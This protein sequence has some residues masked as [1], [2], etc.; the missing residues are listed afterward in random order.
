MAKDIGKKYTLDNFLKMSQNVSQ[1]SAKTPHYTMKGV[2]P[3]Y[4]RNVTAT[5]E[6]Q[7]APLAASIALMQKYT[8]TNSITHMIPVPSASGD[9]AYAD[10]KGNFIRPSV[11]SRLLPSGGT[12]QI[13]RLALFAGYIVT[14]S[15][16][17]TGNLSY[18]AVDSGNVFALTD[19]P[20]VFS[21]VFPAALGAYLNLFVDHRVF[22]LS[23]SLVLNTTPVLDFGIGWN[24]ICEPEVYNN[25]LAIP[26][27]KAS[28]AAPDYNQRFSDNLIYLWNGS[29]SAP[30]Y[31]IPAPGRI[32]GIKN[33][34]NTLFCVIQEHTG[35][36]ALYK[37][38]QYSM[39]KVRSLHGFNATQSATNFVNGNYNCLFARGSTLGI[40]CSN[41]PAGLLFYREDAD[42]GEIFYGYDGN[43]YQMAC[44]AGSAGNLYVSNTTAILYDNQDGAGGANTYNN[45]A[46][47][48]NFME[49][50]Q[51]SRITIYY[52]KPPVQAGDKISI[53]LYGID[54]YANGG[55]LSNETVV[56]DD[57]TSTAFDTS[58]RTFRD[59]KGFNG[60]K[61]RIGITTTVS[62]GTT[63][64]PC[65]R[66]V[67]IHQDEPED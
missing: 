16:T 49:V 38:S 17:S 60:N 23:S 47:L 52:D 59:V 41:V 35:E 3:V 55:S 24:I 6:E 36:Y 14:C 57:I 54:E 43:G 7:A 10:S 65:I 30:Q 39:K 29:S 26:M 2:N 66:K 51:V 31:N 58:K 19:I 18:A 61:L 27:Y 42:L 22:Q 32:C 4:Y 13:T 62:N 45:I 15:S 50:D 67:V 11:G 5:Q 20:S 8:S 9:I 25:Y 63:W 64:F 44:V 33:I 40:L 12:T 28:T 34:S 56:L 1:F 46:Y 21:A 48:S 53:T 37:V